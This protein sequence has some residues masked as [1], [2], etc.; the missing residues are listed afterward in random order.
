MEENHTIQLGKWTVP[1]IT[2]FKIWIGLFHLVGIIGL[3]IPFSKPL[4]QQLTPFHLIM[5]AGILL[6]FHRDWNVPF[7]GFALL[8]FVTG[9]VSEIIGVQTGLIFGDYAY[10]TVL[11]IKAWGVPLVIGLNWFLLVYLTGELLH[12]RIQN[13]WVAS[14]FGAV[15]MVGMDFVMEPVAISLDF[16]QWSASNVPVKNYIGWFCISFGLH[17][18]YR[19]SRF[20]KRNPISYFLLLNIAAFFVVLALTL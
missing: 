7:I 2:L 15:L 6:Y 19:Y 16:W 18:A 13:R 3:S 9:M 20:S 11:G 5:S 8:A 12:E 17:V 10:G 4:F 1:K 14:L